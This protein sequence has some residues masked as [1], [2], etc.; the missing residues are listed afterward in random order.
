[1]ADNI[2]IVQA[3]LIAALEDIHDLQERLEAQQE[4]ELRVRDHC[5]DIIADAR[6]YVEALEMLIIEVEAQ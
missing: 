2:E 1:M 5:S 6:M 3:K 4:Q